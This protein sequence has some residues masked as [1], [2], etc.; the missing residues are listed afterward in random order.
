M[1]SD[2]TKAFDDYVGG[3]E[4]GESYNVTTPK[5]DGYICSNSKVSGVMPNRNVTVTIVYIPNSQE[6]PI[7]L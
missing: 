3:Y 4:Y 5:L 6:T 7:I 1:K 2:G